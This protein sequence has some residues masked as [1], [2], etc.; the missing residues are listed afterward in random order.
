MLAL[1]SFPEGT[2]KRV[3]LTGGD[4]GIG[5]AA[6]IA[7][8]REGADVA[9]NYLPP[10]EPDAREVIELI[11]AAGRK[12]IAIPGDIK[13][14]AFCSKLVET[15][16]SQLGQSQAASVPCC[17]ALTSREQFQHAADD[18]ISKGGR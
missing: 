9:I 8:A 10:E 13:D 6:A 18:I 15:A 16:A 4:S 3:V 11:R 1:A 7:Y 12:G 2:G 5:R 17:I 14:E